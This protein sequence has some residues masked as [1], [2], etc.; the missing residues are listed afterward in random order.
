MFRRL[1][2]T[3]LNVNSMMQFPEE[4]LIIFIMSRSDVAQIYMKTGLV[5]IV[6][7]LELAMD[8]GMSIHGFHNHTQQK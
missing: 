5:L 3:S 7:L 4:L 1:K 2:E 6:R 8:Q